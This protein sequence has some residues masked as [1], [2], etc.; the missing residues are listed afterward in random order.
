[1]NRA[2]L[3]WH[4]HL[5]Q[6]LHVLCVVGGDRPKRQRRRR[7]CKEGPVVDEIPHL[8]LDPPGSAVAIS[9]VARQMA[10]VDDA[11]VGAG[12]RGVRRGPRGGVK[13]E[14]STDAVAEA[15]APYLP[16]RTVGA[17]ASD[18]RLGCAGSGR[19][20]DRLTSACHTFVGSYAQHMLRS[21]SCARGSSSMRRSAN[22]KRSCRIAAT[23]WARGVAASIAAS[24]L[25]SD[26]AAERTRSLGAKAGA[27][28]SDQRGR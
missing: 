18:D 1:M 24:A 11:R 8:P 25:R 26:S 19:R 23:S 22:H 6:R 28:W 9:N 10:K 5:P 27:S 13:A 21:H 12:T 17:R 4:A 3:Q 14:S 2:P 7:R 15:R 16:R 20:R